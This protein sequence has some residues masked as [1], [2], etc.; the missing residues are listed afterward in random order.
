MTTV[1]LKQVSKVF[2]GTDGSPFPVLEETS[3]E[4]PSGSFTAIVGPSGC[5]KS[6]LLRLVAGLA[7][8][9]GGTV[10]INGAPVRGVQNTIGFLFQHDALLPWKT[11][12]DNVALG[13]RFR[14]VR[15]EEVRD[16][17][18]DW[19]ARV[20]LKGFE[21]HYPAQLS[22]GMRKRAALAQMLICDPDLLLMDE[23][24]AS[25][26]AQTRVLLQQDL[27]LLCGGGA[28]TILFVTHDL[29]EAVA[30][31]DTVVVMRAGPRSGVKATYPTGLPRPRDVLQVKSHP[32]FAALCRTVWRDLAEEVTKIYGDRDA[33][34][35]WNI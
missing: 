15:E 20:G 9:S 10:S 6:T 19:I 29:E 25:L 18:Q 14:G 35:S 23:P 31:A 34:S 28:K 2:P 4:V 27:L 16:R 33:V 1:S 5:G 24:F 11:A 12:F 13:L 32:R 8:P 21:R 30:L 26:D 7:A 17:C 3:L 22:G